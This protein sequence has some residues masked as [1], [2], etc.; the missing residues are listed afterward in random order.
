MGIDA[1]ETVMPDIEAFQLMIVEAFIE[2]AA[3]AGIVTHGRLR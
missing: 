1:D 3:K 2:L